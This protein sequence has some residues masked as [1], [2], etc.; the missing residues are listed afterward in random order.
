MNKRVLVVL[1]NFNGYDNTVE[2][3]DSLSNL[4]YNYFDVVVVDNS[5]DSS[6]E[7]FS[8]L[9]K[10]NWRFESHFAH[11]DDELTTSRKSGSLLFIKAKQNKGFAAGNNLAIRYCKELNY[12]FIWLLNN[13]T[14]VDSKSLTELVTTASASTMKIGIWGAKLMIYYSPTRIQGVG[15]Y[16]NKWFG[17]VREIGYN[18][19][20][21]GQWDYIQIKYDYVIGASMFVSVDFIKDVGLMEEDYFLYYEELDWAI[22]GKQKGWSMGFCPKCRVYHKMGASI[23]ENQPIRGNSYLSDYYAVRNRILFTKKY[24]PYALL[25]LYPAFLMFIINR[26]RSGQFS[27]IIM[28]FKVII[29]PKKHLK[30]FS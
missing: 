7:R 13:D 20:D 14:V 12:D 9:D 18:Q 3:L 26:I 25:T 17:I 4:D 30:S 16:Y 28:L 15:G 11:E 1:V 5:T 6:F 22:R 2:C 10:S 19:L 24:F 27:R 8:R 21:T 29:N 23:N